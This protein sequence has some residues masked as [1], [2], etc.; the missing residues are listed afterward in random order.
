VIETT[1]DKR[2]RAKAIKAGRDKSIFPIFAAVT[3]SFL[4]AI[5]VSIYSLTMLARENTKEMP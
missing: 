5:V 3:V 1:D 2:R 4:L